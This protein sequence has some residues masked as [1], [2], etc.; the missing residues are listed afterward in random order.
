[1]N[2]ALFRQLLDARQGRPAEEPLR[3]GLDEAERRLLHFLRA[4]KSFA[5]AAGDETALA[6]DVR[7]Q[8]EAALHLPALG[9]GV[10]W[11]ATPEGQAASAFLLAHLGGTVGTWGTLFGWVLV[12]GLGRIAGEANAAGQARTWLDEWLL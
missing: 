5:G 10:T 8:L 12:H 6:R 9:D 3:Q 11:P 7:R 4:V 1:V 2:A